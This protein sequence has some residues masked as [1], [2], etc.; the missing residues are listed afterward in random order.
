MKKTM[1]IAVAMLLTTLSCQKNITSETEP[2][3]G[4][5]P[6]KLTLTASIAGPETK[7]I[8]TEK[9]NALKFAWE[10]GDKVSL[11][12]IDGSGN[13]LSNDVLTAKSGGAK[14]QFEGT[15]SNPEN[16]TSVVVYYPAL[17][18]G[19]GSK[20]KPWMSK[21]YDNCPDGVGVL[22]DCIKGKMTIRIRNDD[23]LQTKNGDTSKLKHYVVMKGDISNIQALKTGKINTSLKNMCY[24]IKVRAKIP[25]SFGQVTAMYFECDHEI[26]SGGSTVLGADF[27]KF[28]M[29][30]TFAGVYFGDKLSDF[31]K[32]IISTGVPI[33]SEGYVTAYM[34]CYGCSYGGKG[35][36]LPSGTKINVTALDSE[37]KET[38]SDDFTLTKD[39]TLKPGNMY[40]FNVEF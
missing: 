24:V 10:K 37:G 29:G 33:D 2:T 38:I 5:P 17:T 19:D 21:D 11:I 9:D 36:H 20:E 25:E 28:T 26:S 13:A 6:I 18:E 31:T 35:Y 32:D 15:W 40:R 23:H 4:N 39:N 14:A 1:I 34:M 7:V 8:Y 30:N 12:T 16:A 3:N 27:S 22:Y